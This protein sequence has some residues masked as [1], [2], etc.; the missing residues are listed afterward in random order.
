MLSLFAVP[1]ESIDP[2]VTSAF[3]PLAC[4]ILLSG[5]DDI[6]LDS[7]CLF[8]WMTNRILYGEAD[9]RTEH[10]FAMTERQKRIAILVP[11]WKE[12]AVI[13][14]MVRSNIARIQYQNYDF[15]LG[16]YRNDEATLTAVR[17][18]EGEFGNVHIACC[19]NPGPTSKADCLNWLY[20]RM[21]DF[22]KQRNVRFEV[23]ITH[24]AEDVIHAHALHWLNYYIGIYDM[25]QI[26]VLPLP[27]P[28]RKLTHGIY[29]DEFA[30]FQ[31]KDMPGRQ[32]LQ[33][34][35]PSNGVG[36]GYSRWAMDQLASRGGRIFEP[37]CLTEDYENGLRIHFL[38]APQLFMPVRFHKDAPVATREYFPQTARSAI[39]QRTRWVTG[40]ALQ[41]W[42]R[43]GFRG[44]IGTLYWLWRDRKGLIGNPVS[45]ITSMMFLY[46]ALTWMISRF[47]GGNWG[48]GHLTESPAVLYLLSMTTTLQFVHLGVRM[49]CTARIYG[50]R[51]A[52]FV[53][54]RAVYANYINFR[55]TVGA[56]R[57]YVWSRL[58]GKPL[59]WLKTDHVYPAFAPTP[60]RT[61]RLGEILVG[62][63]RLT[64]QQLEWAMAAK[65]QGIR[66]GE[67]LVSRGLLSEEQLYHALSLQ[68][69][70]PLSALDPARVKRSVARSLPLHV[71]E[72]WRVLPFQVTDGFLFVVSPEL[73][74][75]T[76]VEGLRQFTRLQIRM[77]LVT[78]SNFEALRQE[79][80]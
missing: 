33:G 23:I 34:F 22:E 70:T 43:H 24:D 47:T 18:L 26:P 58:S 62:Q 11:L 79:L 37:E 51:F 68:S 74:R 77:Q 10:D 67:F 54:V 76:I 73:P 48:M 31:L 35:I 72:S 52:S 21:L 1:L 78:Q 46:G 49:W 17:Q 56:I 27:T 7:V 3:V 66:L 16:A 69:A 64:G 32:I 57:R 19:G 14:D 60:A 61:R 6:F 30:E 12:D 40:I 42:E 28:L 5:L 39:K 20:R 53:P 36:T 8:T 59:V 13:R 44:G 50:W 63:S 45:M 65:P 29:C 75:P 4:W 71:V 41:S 9:L 25:V 38:G 80:L 55:A 15:F 2:W